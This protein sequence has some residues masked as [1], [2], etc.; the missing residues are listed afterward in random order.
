MKKKI[1]NIINTLIVPSGL[2]M[3]K[4]SDR[5]K[6]RK[7]VLL[8]SIILLLFIIIALYL[9]VYIAI[10][11]WSSLVE[12]LIKLSYIFLC[13]IT[14]KKGKIN[15]ASTLLFLGTYLT[16]SMPL[17]DADVTTQLMC[18]FYGMLVITFYGLFAY[19]KYV[20]L[21]GLLVMTLTISFVIYKHAFDVTLTVRLLIG[22]VIVITAGLLCSSSLTA[23]VALADRTEEVEALHADLQVAYDQLEISSSTDALTG[24]YNRKTT[25]QIIDDYICSYQSVSLIFIDLDNFKQINDTYGHDGGDI[26]LKEMVKVIQ[27]HSLDSDIVGRWGGEEFVIVLPDCDM[28][29]SIVRAERYRKAIFETKFPIGNGLHF[30]C[31]IGVATTPTHANTQATLVCAADAAM[32]LAKKSGKNQVR[33]ASDPEVIKTLVA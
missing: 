12:G 10:Q 28:H 14:C 13:L 33:N 21:F 16:F 9:P 18:L 30:T 17:L 29:N 15:L 24:A 20:L 26:A 31:S 32:Y 27:F 19:W 23:A 7:S 3:R 25:T 4:A 11:E 6:R 2:D 8:G 22:Q 1:S 5:E